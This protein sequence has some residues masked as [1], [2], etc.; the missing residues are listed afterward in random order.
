MFVDLL[1]KDRSDWGKKITNVHRKASSIQN[2]FYIDGYF[3]EIHMG[4]NI[5]PC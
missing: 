5:L 4:Y 1:D 2:S 3:V